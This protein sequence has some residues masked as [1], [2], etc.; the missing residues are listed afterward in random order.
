MDKFELGLNMQTFL[1]VLVSIGLISLCIYL[2]VKRFSN[3]KSEETTKWTPTDYN[4]LKDKIN[5]EINSEDGKNLADGKPVEKYSE[6]AD[7]QSVELLDCVTNRFTLEYNDP[8]FIDDSEFKSRVQK[9]KVYCEDGLKKHKDDPRNNTDPDPG[10]PVWTDEI[11]EKFKSVIK[12]SL[13]NAPTQPTP[14]QLECIVRNIVSRYKFPRN[15]PKVNEKQTNEMIEEVMKEC[16]YNLVSKIQWDEDSISMLKFRIMLTD[17][18]TTD[19][20]ILYTKGLISCVTEDI[21]SKITNLDDITIPLLEA[22]KKKCRESG[23]KILINFWPETS[24]NK[25]RDDMS[26]EFKRMV[27]KDNADKEINCIVHTI[28]DIFKNS[29]E[30]EKLK[31]KL[32]KDDLKTF[33]QVIFMNC[34]SLWTSDDDKVYN[35]QLIKDKLMKLG[36]TV[37]NMSLPTCILNEI[38]EIYKDPKKIPKDT[39]GSIMI[40]VI[41]DMYKTCTGK[42]LPEPESLWTESD[43]QKYKSDISHNFNMKFDTLINGDLG[44]CL[45]TELKKT[46]PNHSKI[47]TDLVPNININHGRKSIKDDVLKNIYKICTGKDLPEPHQEK[48]KNDFIGVPDADIRRLIE[49]TIPTA[50][51]NQVDCIL[52]EIKSEWQKRNSY[53][54]TRTLI[55]KKI[56]YEKCKNLPSPTPSPLTDDDYKKSI[57]SAIRIIVKDKITIPALAADRIL[58]NLKQ[59]GKLVNNPNFLNDVKGF[60]KLFLGSLYTPDNVTELKKTTIPKVIRRI[61]HK[62]KEGITFLI[63]N[64]PY[65]PKPRNDHKYSDT[66]LDCIITKMKTNYNGDPLDWSNENDLVDFFIENIRECLWTPTQVERIKTIMKNMT[67]DERKIFDKKFTGTSDSN[68]PFTDNQLVCFIGELKEYFPDPNVFNNAA[69]LNSISLNIFDTCVR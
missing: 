16:K 58:Y 22:S 7:L 15:L 21:L 37:D 27:G 8:K 36:I 65:I 24:R 42:D 14:D 49:S 9:L 52:N 30:Y 40:S 5:S 2:L 61:G 38:K 54:A 33:Y 11:I 55:I 20:P 39:D 28:E 6:L 44:N 17:V 46:Y 19:V 51:P 47:P 68:K 59:T 32:T 63:N 53:A 67:Y 62:G 56:M 35:I 4:K 29:E 41:K 26:S 60:Y 45:L 69:D 18:S 66:E 13:E 1:I 64:L 34:L 25:L 10:P 43:I 48:Q 12:Q 3:K 23:L 50:Q 57:E 31:S